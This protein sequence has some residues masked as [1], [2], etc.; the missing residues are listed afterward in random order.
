[1]GGE[2]VGSA[3]AAVV[4]PYARRHETW[5]G[6]AFFWVALAALAFVG[7]LLTAEDALDG[8]GGLIHTGMHLVVHGHTFLSLW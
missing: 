5:I 6:R 7:E 1:V 8:G 2:E 3:L 4:P